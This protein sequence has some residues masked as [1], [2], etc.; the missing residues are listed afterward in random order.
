MDH[1]ELK[2]PNTTVKLEKESD[3]FVCSCRGFLYFLQLL[4]YSDSVF[5]V[6]LHKRDDKQPE[7][8]NKL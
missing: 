8:N 3:M 1:W 6:K 5:I 2:A 4:T 7:R